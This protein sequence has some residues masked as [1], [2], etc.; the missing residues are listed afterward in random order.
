MI[1]PEEAEC[2]RALL[3]RAR[4]V[5]IDVDG[6]LVAGGVAL[7]GAAEFLAALGPR[8]FIVSNNSIDTPQSMTDK[9]ARQGLGVAPQRLTLAGATMIDM[10]AAEMPDDA[11]FLVAAAS[12]AAYATERGLRLTDAEGRR[13]WRWR[14]I[15]RSPMH[16]CI[17]PP[18]CCMAAPAGWW[19]IPTVSTRTP[20]A[21]RCRKPGR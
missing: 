21:D 7:P 12:L 3:G 15:P 5:L 18:G 16:A 2:A 8:A 6:V 1:L 19:R 10:I 11:V 4:A 9:F 13:S 17:A 20:T 14:G